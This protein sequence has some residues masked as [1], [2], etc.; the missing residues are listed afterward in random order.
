[1][2][3][4]EVIS[5]DAVNTSHNKKHKKAKV[6]VKPTSKASSQAIIK[7]NTPVPGFD[8]IS[9]SE[10]VTY[11]KPKSE[12]TLRKEKERK[13]RHDFLRLRNPGKYYETDEDKLERKLRDER[14]ANREEDRFNNRR[15]RIWDMSHSEGER[16]SFELD[17][18]ARA[19]IDLWDEIYQAEIKEEE[20]LFMNR[21]K[22]N[23]Y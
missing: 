14:F 1:M 5:A 10:V 8:V 17:D 12:A 9:V 15:D 23:E 13:A 3:G 4:Y 11:K 18:D 19:K 22:R 21:I 7:D 2:S 16:L 6:K 20:R